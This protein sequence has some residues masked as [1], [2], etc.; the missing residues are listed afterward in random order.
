[1]R[2]PGIPQD[3]GGNLTVKAC[4]SK[5]DIRRVAGLNGEIHGREEGEAVRR[6]LVEGHP[7]IEPDGWLFVEDG[8]TGEAV[9]TLSLMP[10]TWRYGPVS[11][12]VAELGFVAT[13]PAYRRRGLQR[14]LAAAFDRIALANGYALAAIEGIP[15]FYRQFGYEY[16]LPLFDS[17]F[18]LALDQIPAGSLAPFAFRPAA[19]ADIPFLMACYD[20]QNAD[21]TITTERPEAMW[22]YSLSLP[23]DAVFGLRIVEIL[24]DERAL[25]YLA[26][27]PSGWSNRL[28]VVE[29]AG[30]TREMILA[31][32]RFARA[33]AE[34]SGHDGVG[35]QLPTDHLASVVAR[36][37]GIKEERTYGWQMKVLDP[38]RFLNTISPAL[39]ERLAA[40][41]LRGTS[42]ELNWNLYRQKVGLR[43]EDGRVS[44]VALDLEAET[45]VNI[46]PLVATQLWLGWKSFAQL[47]DWHKDVWAQEEKRF[48]LDVLFPPVEA[49]IYL[50]Y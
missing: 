33:Q 28:N 23:P 12:P 32:L 19:P 18:N 46:P 30:D 38:V 49:H 14:A 21:L 40:S 1:L 22:R 26:L 37:Q 20:Q 31:A 45:E 29:L 27:A 2:L 41:V 4:A 25:G 34:E 11:L 24:R 9:A 6:W 50:G 16:A 13:R 15:Y 43:L 7:Q 35:L 3:L 48:L 42:G 10:L 36:Y 44:A 5:H 47:D 39:D 17:R 8:T